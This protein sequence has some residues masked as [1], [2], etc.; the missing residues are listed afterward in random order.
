MFDG[1]P[2]PMTGVSF[3]KSISRSARET[4]TRIVVPLLA[5]T[6]L[7][8]P[9]QP[10]E[11]SFSSLCLSLSLFL[12]L[13]LSIAFSSISPSLLSRRDLSRSLVAKL[14]S[15]GRAEQRG[16]AHFA[17]SCC[18]RRN[19]I[20]ARAHSVPGNCAREATWNLH[21]PRRFAKEVSP[22]PLFHPPFS[23]SRRYPFRCFEIQSPG[24]DQD[25]QRHRKISP[26]SIPA[27]EQN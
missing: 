22:R 19:F 26:R 20:P 4:C 2:W 27:V 3:R 12:S 1:S 17:C 14:N 18:T 5:I 16:Y 25:H 10:A 9:I 11:I 8:Q 23:L 21:L 7:H 13:S 6:V 15:P 24:R